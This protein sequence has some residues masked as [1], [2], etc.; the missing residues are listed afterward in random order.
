MTK[1]VPAIMSGGSGTRLWPVSTASRPKQF[2]QILS[3]QPMIV[4]TA[5]RFREPGHGLTFTAP[6]FV[7]GEPHRSILQE[8]VEAAGI[9]PAAIVLEPM[10]RNTAAA[11]AVAALVA[12]EV[13][14]DAKVLL[15]PADHLIRDLD[16][17]HAAIARTSSVVE[18]S[19]VTFGMSPTAPETG[20]GYIEQGTEITD[21]VFRIASFKEKPDRETAQGYL[22]AGGYSWNSGIFFYSPEVLIAEFEALQ[23]E[24]IAQVRQAVQHGRKTG[25]EL[26]LDADQ[27]AKVES[28]PVDIAI[29]EKTQKGAVAPCAIDWAD[30]GSWAEYW[31]L[32]EKDNSG[33]A[34]E[35][36]VIVEDVENALVRAEPGMQVSVCGVSDVIVIATRDNVLVLPRAEAQRVKQLI[37]KS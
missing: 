6:I 35:G 13:A 11:A 23:P 2:Q 1:I 34:L 21:G 12:M 4:E 22:D 28:L 37:P 24:L 36:S 26:L 31:R 5:H 9:T 30:V 27:F 18:D 25:Q 32:S 19:I 3:S 8:E 7:A 20:F 17:F 15:L 14:P 33:N 16:A 29:M 10:G